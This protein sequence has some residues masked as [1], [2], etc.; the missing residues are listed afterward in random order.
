MNGSFPH[1]GS[2][3]CGEV[4]EVGGPALVCLYCLPTMVPGEELSSGVL[5]R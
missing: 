1:L 5:A 4:L 2:Q 3:G